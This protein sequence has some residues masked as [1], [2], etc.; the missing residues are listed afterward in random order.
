M[1]SLTFVIINKVIMTCDH[2]QRS[3]DISSFTNSHG[4]SLLTK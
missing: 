2:C 1:L 4:R 3:S